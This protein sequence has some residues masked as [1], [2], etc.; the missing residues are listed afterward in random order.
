MRGYPGS[1]LQTLIIGP[2]SGLLALV[3]LAIFGLKLFALVDA[4]IRPKAAWQAAVT[5]SKTMWVAILAVALLLNGIG[6]FGIV[7][8]VAT[9]LYLVDVRP[10]LKDVQG[11]GSSRW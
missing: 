6:L 9:I 10:K 3:S 4:A 11:R 8:M 1:V 7:A 2:F 5:Q